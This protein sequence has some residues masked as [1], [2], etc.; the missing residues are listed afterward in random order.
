MSD[1]N[2]EGLDFSNFN[3]K[4]SA[5]AIVSP[6][7]EES[8]MQPLTIARSFKITKR[9]KIMIGVLIALIIA[10]LV[11]YFLRNPNR[12]GVPEGYEITPPVNGASYPAINK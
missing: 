7:T 3:A 6:I 8:P 2:E 9:A 12:S 1:K 5:E 4:P 10:Q 11:I